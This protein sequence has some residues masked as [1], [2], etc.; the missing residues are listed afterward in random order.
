MNQLVHDEVNAKDGGEGVFE[1]C[2]HY[3]RSEVE[4]VRPLPLVVL[5]VAIPH[6]MNEI[7]EV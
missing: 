3:R 4:Q 7:L 1:K 6:V 2:V 5:E